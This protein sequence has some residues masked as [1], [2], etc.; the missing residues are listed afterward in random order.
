MKLKHLIC[1][2]EAETY[3]EECRIKTT[4]SI[5]RR[6]IYFKEDRDHR[7]A[8]IVTVRSIQIPC[9]L[10][11]SYEETVRVVLHRCR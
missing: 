10:N 11:R 7:I 1:L 3:L 6:R 9:T 8:R 2:D 5:L 4:M